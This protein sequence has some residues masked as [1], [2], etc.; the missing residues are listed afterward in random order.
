MIEL[1]MRKNLGRLIPYDAVGID[2][3]SAIA[4]GSTITAR[5]TQTRNL[6]HHRLWFALLHVVFE[7]QSFFATVDELHDE[8]KIATGHFSIRK[9]PDGTTYPHPNSI[10]FAKLGQ[11][12]FKEF[13]DKAVGIIITNILPNVQRE[14]IEQ[15]VYE[16]L[17]EPGPLDLQRRAS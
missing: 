11:Q 5:I 2:Q 1:L 13:F 6:Q 10:S 16:L 3:L 4:E 17:G 9:R 7:A 14:D 8:I 15:R 12:G